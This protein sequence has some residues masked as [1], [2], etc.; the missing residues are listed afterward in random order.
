MDVNSQ[1]FWLVL[2]GVLQ[3]IVDCDFAVIDLEMS[4]GVTDHD[5]SRFKGLSAK[6]LAYAMA[7]RAASQHNIVELGLTLITSPKDNSTPYTTTTYNFAVNNLFLK[8]T[9]DQFFLQRS[10]ERVIDFSASAL[11]FFKKRGLDPMTLNGFERQQHAGVP[12]LSRKER[13]DAI[14][15]ASSTKVF[16]PVDEDELDVDARTFFEATVESISKWWKSSPRI[17]AEIL[18]DFPGCFHE[19]TDRYGLRVTVTDVHNQ[20]VQ[21][22]KLKR[23]IEDRNATIKKQACLSIIFEALCGGNFIDLI[24][25]EELSSTLEACPGWR[26]NVED[27][28]WLLQNCQTALQNNPPVLVAHN[29]FYDMT[30]LYDT[31]V[32]HLPATLGEFQIEF[33]ALFPRIIDTKVFAISM[34]KIDGIDSL[35]NL[36]NTFRYDHPEVVYDRGF[37][38]AVEQ[39]WAHVAGFDTYMTAV[40][41]I[42]AGH[43]KM[44][45]A[46]GRLP[47]WEHEF[48][49][50]ARNTIRL[51]RGI[52][53]VLGGPTGAAG[54]CVMF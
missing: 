2:P 14:D 41:L 24:N 47:A 38:Y 15:Q 27:L 35:G 51:G 31:F 36:F 7:S 32:G 28:R 37:G 45:I 19:Q 25:A 20:L 26:D 3:R 43:K 48:W 1:N 46:K 34:D 9:R 29:M 30:F 6:E 13:Q 21:Q 22:E 18:V 5:E 17:V 44:G 12:F 40:V 52:K 33:Q 4:G 54:G 53:H 10:Q 11:E 16:R 8:G 39:G 49:K 50:E 23:R 42:R